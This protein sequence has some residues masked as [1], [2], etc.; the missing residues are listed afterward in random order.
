MPLKTTT[1]GAYQKPEF[2]GLTDWFDQS[3]G[4]TTAEKPTAHYTR[5]LRQLGDQAEALFVRAAEAVIRDQ[6]AA[7]IDILTDGEVRRENYIHYHCR[8]LSGINFE[9]LTEQDLRNG[10]YK[11]SLPTIT[12][13]VMA[14][15]PFLTHDWK[16]AQALT[17]RDVKITIPGPMTIGD[18]VA[19]MFYNDPKKRGAEIAD[20][21]NR[22]V[23]A[24][25][26][27]GCIHIQIDEP[28]FARK[29]GDALDYGFENLERCFHNVPNHVV[30]TV[31]MCCGYPDRMDNPDYEKA[32]KAC[33]FDLAPAIEKSS[34]QA[35][36]IEDAHRNNDLSLLEIFE[37][38]TVIF[39]VVAIAKS[40]VESVDMLETRLRNALGHIDAHRLIAAPDCGLGLLGRDLAQRKLSNLC[41]AVRRI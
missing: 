15:A 29:V 31:H 14:M 28:V 37:K 11:A 34:I 27:A 26:D 7:G 13:P 38:T 6:E 36:S 33:Y 8:H 21:L 32:D 39:G 9:L 40:H 25:A 35:V 3:L 5:E 19:D 12:G 23:L 4:G 16:T 10:A 22:E 30:R 17:R 2:L 41:D 20:A 18:T 1:I 24:L